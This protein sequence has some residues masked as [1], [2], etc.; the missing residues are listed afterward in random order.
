MAV[1]RLTQEPDQSNF[2]NEMCSVICDPDQPVN[3][4]P[5]I[6]WTDLVL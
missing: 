5:L 4:K 3:Q 6:N 2:V 1:S